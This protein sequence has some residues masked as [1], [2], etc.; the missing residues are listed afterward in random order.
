MICECYT[1][2]FASL[3]EPRCDLFV[4]LTGFKITARMIVRHILCYL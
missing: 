4:S 2:H 3:F 1:E